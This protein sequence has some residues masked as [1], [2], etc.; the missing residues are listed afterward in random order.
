MRKGSKEEP[1]LDEVL[2]DVGSRLRLL[3]EAQGLSQRELAR[4]AKMTNANLSLIEQGKVSPSLITLERIVQ[5]IPLSLAAFFSDV[6]SLCAS[7]FRQAQTPVVT[8][9]GVTFEAITASLS[10]EQL[11]FLG[12]KT[13]PALAQIDGLWVRNAQVLAGRVKSGAVHLDL[14][15]IEYLMLGGDSF[16]FSAMR[17]HRFI[18]RSADS[19]ELYF[20][21]Y[22]KG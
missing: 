22:A 3:R 9:D 6:D 12:L 2:F 10:S 5:A 17:K 15:G 8:R 11:L 1:G 13:L 16:Q 18:N 14:D 20:C 4:R 21:V 19:A 7:V